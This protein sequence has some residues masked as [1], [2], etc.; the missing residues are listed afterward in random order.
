MIKEVTVFHY[1]TSYTKYGY[2]VK[3][4]NKRRSLV[5]GFNKIP[6][7][8]IDFLA[9]HDWHYSAEDSMK[10]IPVYHVF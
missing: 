9:S 8:V 10:T 4:E 5:E 3:Y 6:K 2:V 1:N 7:T